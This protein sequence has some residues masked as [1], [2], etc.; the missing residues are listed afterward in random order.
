M[1]LPPRIVHFSAVVVYFRVALGNLHDILFGSS[2]SALPAESLSL[3]TRTILGKVCN[4]HAHSVPRPRTID[5]STTRVE[6]GSIRQ[7]MEMWPSP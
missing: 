4:R 7:D 1:E 6:G 2:R 5:D 3:Y